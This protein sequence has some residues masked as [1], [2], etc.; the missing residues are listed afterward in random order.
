MFLSCQVH[1]TSRA[2]GTQEKKHFSQCAEYIYCSAKYR[3]VNGTLGKQ[4]QSI[5]NNYTINAGSELICGK[6]ETKKRRKSVN[7]SLEFGEY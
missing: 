1:L 4:M 3:P 7:N 2:T 5:K 6:K